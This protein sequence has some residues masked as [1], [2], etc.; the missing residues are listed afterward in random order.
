VGGRTCRQRINLA[1]AVA[2]P[3]GGPT[4]IERC[5]DEDGCLRWT[6]A[7]GFVSAVA[8]PLGLVLAF[9]GINASQVESDRSMFDPTYAGVP[10][11]RPLAAKPG[12][13]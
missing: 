11:R 13:G 8:I 4:D 1:I 2:D 10:L 5:A 9:F 3:G 7:I 12:R 6:V